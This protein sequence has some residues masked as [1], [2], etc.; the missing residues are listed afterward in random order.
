MSEVYEISIWEE[1]SVWNLF[2]YT[3]LTR[4]I[5]LISSSIDPLPLPHS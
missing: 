5:H 4:L 3:M 2:G 1:T